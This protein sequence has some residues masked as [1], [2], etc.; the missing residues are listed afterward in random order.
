[1]EKNNP[2]SFED[3]IQQFLVQPN[4][5]LRERDD[6]TTQIETSINQW[7][8]KM[9]E[10]PNTKAKL[11]PVTYAPAVT[12]NYQINTSDQLEQARTYQLPPRPKQ[13]KEI[14][15]HSIHFPSSCKCGYQWKDEKAQ[16]TAISS[17]TSTIRSNLNSEDDSKLED[18]HICE[19]TYEQYEQRYG[20]KLDEIKESPL[21]ETFGEVHACD[22]NTDNLKFEVKC[23]D[24]TL[25][26]PASMRLVYDSNLYQSL[27][28]CNEKN[29]G[30]ITIWVNKNNTIF[31]I[32][33][34]IIKCTDRIQKEWKVQYDLSFPA[35]MI[36]FVNV[37]IH[38][39]TIT[40]NTNKYDSHM[41]VKLHRQI[42]MIEDW[43][44]KD[45][46]T[47][48]YTI[49][50]YIAVCCNHINDDV[51]DVSCSMGGKRW[52]LDDLAGKKYKV[53]RTLVLFA[54]NNLL[55]HIN[56]IRNLHLYDRSKRLAEDNMNL[57]GSES[58][59][60]WKKDVVS[61]DGSFRTL[62]NDSE[63]EDDDHSRQ[64]S[65]TQ[66]S[67]NQPVAQPQM[68]LKRTNQAAKKIEDPESYFAEQIDSHNQKEV[69]SRWVMEMKMAKNKDN[70]AEY[71]A[72]K[73][74]YDQDREQAKKELENLMMDY[75]LQ[76]EII[77]RGSN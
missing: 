69:F 28:K 41:M 11:P 8:E 44:T 59:Y 63:M 52:K 55:S 24:L 12:D 5:I 71:Q 3:R 4:T 20:I 13:V 47:H 54:H 62:N 46:H 15:A 56:E 34:I 32:L 75:K 23:E 49:W 60:E 64:G 68:F 73:A 43:Y 39:K 70:P 35:Y 30:S 27:V 36:N 9:N 74:K 37:I 42:N 21:S 26:D 31:N 66:N 17:I 50:L 67:S 61:E 77:K 19:I 29:N 25:R 58:A 48:I 1:M 45:N 16:K 18:R 57:V 6:A 40:P 33:S 7:R 22:A 76:I 38:T 65:S 72:L 14:N 53:V 10:Q 2:Q 51:I